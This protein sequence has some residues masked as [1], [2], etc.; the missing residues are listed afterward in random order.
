VDQTGNDEGATITQ[1]NTDSSLANVTQS[2]IR[3]RATVNQGGF[4]GSTHHS[5]LVANVTQSGANNTGVVIQRG[6]FNEANILQTGSF[7]MATITQTGFAGAGVLRN[8]ATINQSG[9]GNVANATQALGSG[10]RITI[11]QN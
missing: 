9:F 4:L 5:F 2:G 3:Q 6:R 7:N 1:N 11:T 8:I 10:N